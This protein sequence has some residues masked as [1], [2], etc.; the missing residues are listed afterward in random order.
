MQGACI[1]NSSNNKPTLLIYKEHPITYGKVILIVFRDNCLY[2]MIISS[3]TLTTIIPLQAQ[4][5][6]TKLPFYNN[7]DQMVEEWRKLVLSRLLSTELD[8]N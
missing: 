4:H 1:Y 6:L 7:F 5:I 8:K 3:R 2:K